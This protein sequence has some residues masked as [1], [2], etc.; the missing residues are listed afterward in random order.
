MDEDDKFIEQCKG[1]G[2][3]AWTYDDHP[4]DPHHGGKMT[5]RQMAEEIEKLRAAC[6][7]AVDF[8]GDQFE[9][10]D[11]TTGRA[12]TLEARPVMEAL[13]EAMYPLKGEDDG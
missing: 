5:A 7:L 1:S 2:H 6:D 10:P 4:T 13:L 3:P 8:I 9:E 12:Y 11:P